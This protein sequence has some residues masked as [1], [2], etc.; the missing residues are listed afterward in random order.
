M[1]LKKSFSK[2]ITTI[3]IC[4]ELVV[5][6]LCF[7][8][9][10]SYF[11]EKES[12]DFYN[13]AREATTLANMYAKS[14]F[15]INGFKQRIKSYS[16]GATDISS[17]NRFIQSSNKNTFRVRNYYT[18]NGV[19][20][21]PPIPSFIKNVFNDKAGVDEIKNKLIVHGEIAT[22]L[23]IFKVGNITA[24]SAY[25]ISEDPILR[26]NIKATSLNGFCF[27][28]GKKNIGWL[29]DGDFP[30]DCEMPGLNDYEFGLKPQYVVLENT[31]GLEGFRFVVSDAY[32]VHRNNKLLLF[33]GFA[34]CIKFLISVILTII[35][36]KISTKHLDQVVNDTKILSMKGHSAQVRGKVYKYREFQSLMNTFLTVLDTRESVENQLII[37]KDRMED[38]VRLRTKELTEAVGKAE[39]A[40]KSKMEFLASVSHEIRTPMNCII[41]FCE[42]II[43]EGKDINDKGYA[44]RIIEESETLLHL[45]NDILDHSKIESGKM[46][47]E[48]NRIHLSNFI[49][50]II[51]LGNPF[52]G[53]DKVKVGFV[54]ENEL[55]T[56][57][58]GDKVRLYQVISNLYFNALKYTSEGSISV[59]V[60]L[61]ERIDED[62]NLIEF[63]VVDTGIGIPTDK[64]SGIFDSYN[65][66][67]G[68]L[69]KEYR[70]TGLGLTITKKLVDLMKGTITVTSEPGVGSCFTVQLPVAVVEQSKPAKK[71]KKKHFSESSEKQ[72]KILIVEDYPT[73][74]IVARKHLEA[75]GHTVHE[76]E[77][78]KEGVELCYQEKYDLIL[79]D[80]QMPVM[81]G[82][83]ATRKIR[84]E[85][86]LNGETPIFAMTAN[87]FQSVKDKCYDA[88]MDNI[89]LKPIRRE[90][91]LD[92]IHSFLK[93]DVLV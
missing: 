90:S 13:N 75:A 66:V 41:G 1:K 53:S 70:G 82:F 72:L 24:V 32:H 59:V 22:V 92:S 43:N 37:A 29:I 86:G 11:L 27:S 3:A 14:K 93:G 76:V 40:N 26:K 68:S 35:G 63:S 34:I 5:L 69:T 78:G 4:T 67:E 12:K 48:L 44:K 25:N 45:I 57:I 20:F 62:H 10:F 38:I 87:G 49:N 51:S 81:D 18:L 55:P 52:Y 17:L 61:K 65:Q 79:M 36:K 85:G 8:F 16:S 60:S 21:V 88:G 71:T 46:T 74:R 58:G 9:L 31:M 83:T 77:N 89:I 54:L 91:F 33:L 39:E 2:N 64:I 47:L 56:Y 73:N 28:D 84:G 23:N 80:I 15:K 19:D 6:L 30:Q 7:L 42:L 50:N